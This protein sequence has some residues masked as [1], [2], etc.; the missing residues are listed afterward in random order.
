MDKDRRLALLEEIGAQLCEMDAGNR[1][2]R[3]AGQP[4]RG[5]NLDCLEVAF[6]DAAGHEVGRLGLDRAIHSL[7]GDIYIFED[8]DLADA[9]SATVASI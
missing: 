5:R 4:P 7:A 2:R 3:L 9:V 8:F 6:Q 1:R